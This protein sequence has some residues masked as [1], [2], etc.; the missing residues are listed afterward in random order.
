MRP[1]TF[2]QSIDDAFTRSGARAEWRSPVDGGSGT[3][4]APAMYVPVEGSPE[5]AARIVRA[6]LARPGQRIAALP[7]GT[8]SVEKLADERV[9][10]AGRSRDL[11]LYAIA[12]MDVAPVYV[13]VQRAGKMRLFASI[14]PGWF[15]MVETG[16]ESAAPSLERCSARCA[17]TR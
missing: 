14:Y 15:Q 13:W 1:T 7:G 6:A 12:G 11:S 9:R 16:W 3:L 5:I 17:P 8:L 10:E 2:G 4:S